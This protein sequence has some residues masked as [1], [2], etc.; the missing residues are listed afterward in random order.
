MHTLDPSAGQSDAAPLSVLIIGAGFAGL[1]MAVALR[2][3]GIH[4][5]VLLEKGQDVGGVWR[6]NAYPGAACDVPSHLYSF[7]FEP[8]PRWSRVFAPQAEILAYL[9]HC[10]RKYGLLPY[11]RLGCTVAAAHHEEGRALWRVTLAD[12]QVLWCRVLVSG[13]GQLAGPPGRSCRAS[14]PSAAPASIR[15][16]GT[17]VCRWP[18]GGWRWW[19]PG[20]RPSS[21]CRPSRRRWARCMCSSAR[22]RT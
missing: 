15:R 8:N 9:Q 19:A 1:G 14:R 20:R 4:D 2:K 3:A 18:A 21:S 5:F 22:R 7:S 12:G 6:D 17:P 11:I 10:A 13:T 16:N